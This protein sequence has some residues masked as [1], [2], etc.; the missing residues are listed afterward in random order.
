MIDDMRMFDPGWSDAVDYPTCSELVQWADKRN[1][2][3]TIEHDIVIASSR[4]LIVEVQFDRLE[5]RE[6]RAL[7]I[8][9]STDDLSR[10]IAV[11]AV[12]FAL[13]GPSGISKDGGRM[14]AKVYERSASEKVHPNR[15]FEAQTACA[16]K[17][18]CA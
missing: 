10:C 15:W 17:R 18:P 8:T 5:P 9:N 1:F 2:W 6:Q 3:W 11:V 16:G 7:T 4:P 12:L 14:H 13:K